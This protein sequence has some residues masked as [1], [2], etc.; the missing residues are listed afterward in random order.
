MVKIKLTKSVVDTTQAQTCDVELRDML[1]P[2]F[3][4]KVTPT[5]RKVFMLQYHTNSGVRRKLMRNAKN[6][7]VIQLWLGQYLHTIGRDSDHNVIQIIGYIHFSK[8]GFGFF[9]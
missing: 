6:A 4:C 2:S 7:V 3:L 5:G 1:V 9:L 8:V